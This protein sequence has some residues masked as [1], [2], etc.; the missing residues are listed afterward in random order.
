MP[1][2]HRRILPCAVGFRRCL[3]WVSCVLS[4]LALIFCP[5]SS[6]A[7][8]PNSC[9]QGGAWQSSLKSKE[10]MPITWYT[11][12]GTCIVGVALNV[13]SFLLWLYAWGRLSPRSARLDLAPFSREGRLGPPPFSTVRALLAGGKN[14]QEYTLMERTSIGTVMASCGTTWGEEEVKGLLKIWGSEKIQRE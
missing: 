1:T 2:R 12:N 7:Y 4:L 3:T 5:T 6:Y 8:T 11:Y 10:V 9:P 13:T 14:H